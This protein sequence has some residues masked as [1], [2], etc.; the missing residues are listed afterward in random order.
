MLPGEDRDIRHFFKN[1]NYYVEK[2]G[3]DAAAA[4]A[5]MNAEYPFELA[6]SI[7]G[8]SWNLRTIPERFSWVRGPGYLL[9]D[10]NL[11]K[12]IQFA[13]TKSLVHQ[14]ISATC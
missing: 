14:W 12:E 1:Y 10:A 6:S 13:E 9:L 7:N 2:N 11:K 8:L 4:T 5:P 3:G